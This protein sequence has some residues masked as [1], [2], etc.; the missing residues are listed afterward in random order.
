MSNDSK[1][2]KTVLTNGVLSFNRETNG[3]EVATYKVRIHED[4]SNPRD[5]APELFEQLL[6]DPNANGL[7]HH[8]II[9][10]IPV[11][12]RKKKPMIDGFDG[13]LSEALSRINTQTVYVKPVERSPEFQVLSVLG[14]TMTYGQITKM[15][16]LKANGWKVTKED[17]NQIVAGVDPFI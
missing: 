13:T 1:K 10:S 12:L 3:K 15:G 17:M 9:T 14:K 7:L 2:T 5:V 4:A 16:I 8:W 11:Y 6:N